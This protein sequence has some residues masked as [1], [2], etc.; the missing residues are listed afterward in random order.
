M[1]SKNY[2][3]EVTTL[4]GELV[5]CII[6]KVLQENLFESV[7]IL[8]STLQNNLNTYLKFTTTVAPV[9]LTNGFMHSEVI[10]EDSKGMKVINFTVSPNVSI[11]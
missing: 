1:P 6:N 10:F 4:K 8:Q 5:K 9:K 3:M 2:K 11:D 7:S